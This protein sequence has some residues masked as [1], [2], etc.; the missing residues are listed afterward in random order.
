MLAVS[1][2]TKTGLPTLLDT[3][4]QDSFA[5]VPNGLLG[6]D[7]DE[8]DIHSVLED[9][10][11]EGLSFE[12][13]GLLGSLKDVRHVERSEEMEPELTRLLGMNSQHDGIIF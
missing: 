3:Q 8:N 5:F 4:H 12:R 10:E 13:N 11:L 6:L 9:V 2:S 7:R 1:A